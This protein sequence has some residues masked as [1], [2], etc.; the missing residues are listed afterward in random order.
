MTHSRWLAAAAV[1]TPF[2]LAGCGSPRDAS[3]ANF[4]TALD[5][6]FAHHCVYVSPAVGL[7]AYPATVDDGTDT[8]RFDALVSAGLLTAAQA[9]DEHSGP[10]GIGTVRTTRKTYDLTALG[11]SEYRT[12]TA[13]G[14]GFCAAHYDVVSVDSFTAPTA[15][16]GV[17]VSQVNFTVAPHL[18]PWTANPAI[19]D[20]YGAQLANVKQTADHA[21]LVLTDKGWVVQGDDPAG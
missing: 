1:A 17:T 15:N 21:T 18:E 13:A 6:H 16:N 14:G 10:L 2:L 3:K 11:K 9:T 20:R 8:S 12:D 7:T 19:Q 4:K 5:G